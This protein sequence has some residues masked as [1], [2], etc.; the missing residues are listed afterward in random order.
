VQRERSGRHGQARDSAAP[1]RDTTIVTFTVNVVCNRLSCS[2]MCMHYCCWWLL[3]PALAGY[4]QGASRGLAWLP[5]PDGVCAGCPPSKP[6][7]AGLP[8]HA[9]APLVT[10]DKNKAPPD[11]WL[12]CC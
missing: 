5:Q 8:Q 11:I 6:K 3:D 9:E 4:L 1:V 10:L 7:H 12:L 2:T